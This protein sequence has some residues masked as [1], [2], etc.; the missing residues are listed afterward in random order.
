MSKSPVL[1][2]FRILATIYTDVFR[3]IPVLLVFLLVG[4]GVPGL[5]FSLHL[6]S[7]LPRSMAASR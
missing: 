2:P 1:L 6:V 3:G 7:S 4:F 5:R